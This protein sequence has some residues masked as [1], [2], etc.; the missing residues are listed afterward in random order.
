LGVDALNAVAA[1]V[2]LALGFIGAA[3]FDDTRAVTTVTEAQNPESVTPIELPNGRRGLR[4]AT[5]T[6]VELGRFERIASAS[7][8][9]DQLLVELCE[10]ERIIA[11]TTRSAEYAADAYRYVE[12]SKIYSLDDAEP[13]LALNPDLVLVNNVAGS[14]RV[15]RLREAGLVVFDLGELRGLGT[16]LP[17]IETIAW[18]VGHPE[19]GARIWVTVT[20]TPRR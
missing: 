13:L 8:L 16:L 18:L 5:G 6:L 1:L 2:A 7:T 14:A 15:A 3:A 11:F 19:R 17:S 10:P 9:A 20:K 12:K 4:D